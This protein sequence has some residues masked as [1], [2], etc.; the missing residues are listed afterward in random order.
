[1]RAAL[2]TAAQF[3]PSRTKILSARGRG[4]EVE[5]VEVPA[6]F[7]PYTFGL[8]VLIN[9]RTASASEIVAGALQDHKRAVLVGSKTYGK[10]SV[11][12]YLKGELGDGSGFKF[13]I[14]RYFT[15]NGRWIDRKAG[16][17]FGL[18]PDFVVDLTEKE[19]L[20]LMA[21]WGDAKKKEGDEAFVDRQLEKATE[22]VRTLLWKEGGK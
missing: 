1:M 6:G 9:D 16:K 5:S 12:Q 13:T 3:L 7:T 10:G 15:P 2:D 14:A 8:A 19:T 4:R 17:D 21:S 18:E 22:V 11:Q 20:A